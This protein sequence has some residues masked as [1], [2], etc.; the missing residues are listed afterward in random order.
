MGKI[1]IYS[2]TFIKKLPYQENKLKYDEELNVNPDAISY[3][4][5]VLNNKELKI[6]TNI[7]EL[8]NSIKSLRTYN[9][10]LYTVDNGNLKF[11]ENPVQQKNILKV[12]YESIPTPKKPKEK[13][14][15]EDLL[16]KYKIGYDLL[17]TDYEGNI[18]RLR[19]NINDIKPKSVFT[20]IFNIK[21]KQ[22]VIDDIIKKEKEF[23]IELGKY[24]NIKVGGSKT[25]FSELNTTIGNIAELIEFTNKLKS[26]TYIFE[27]IKNISTNIEKIIEIISSNLYD[28]LNLLIKYINK[29][30]TITEKPYIN[31]IND[32]YFLSEI[33]DAKDKI[34][35]IPDDNENK[36]Y[37]KL[38]INVCKYFI[39]NFKED[40]CAILT[41]E[42]NYI[43]FYLINI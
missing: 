32:F 5:F 40:K 8:K 25:N 16:K 38:C 31:N 6:I 43:Y 21:D 28:Y 35:L 9:P 22:K 39:D 30:K 20:S 42:S 13:I 24:K 10:N 34:L 23:I 1:F 12:Y 3:A 14:K 37:K 33:K 4:K 36:L 2:I 15:L 19:R 26:V 7:D 29:L 41:D 18:D 27:I 11:L 17:I